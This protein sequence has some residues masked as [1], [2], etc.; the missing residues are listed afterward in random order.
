MPVSSG[1]R[2]QPTSSLTGRYPG[3]VLDRGESVAKNSKGQLSLAVIR[4]ACIPAQLYE[5]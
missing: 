3:S 5:M 2:Q 1:T 4:F